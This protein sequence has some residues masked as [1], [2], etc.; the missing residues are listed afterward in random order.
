PNNESAYVKWINDADMV[1]LVTLLGYKM[2]ILILYLRLFA[3]NRT[4][5]Y[6]TW[7]M[8]FLVCGYLMANLLT[9]IFGCSPRSKYWEPGT[10]GHCI[11]YTTA[12]LAYGSMNIVS[13]L[14]ILIL[15]IP[16]VW[17]LELSRREK[18]SISVIFMSGTITCVA[19]AVRYVYIV[20]ENQADAKYFI[21]SLVEINIGVIC[22]CMPAFRPFFARVL[23]RVSIHSLTGGSW[24]SKYRRK[25][26]EPHEEGEVVEMGRYRSIVG[27]HHDSAEQSPAIELPVG[28][29]N[30]HEIVTKDGRLA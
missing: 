1:Y 25:N 11:D 18:V 7:S 2:S 17:Q 12:G 4:F 15:P 16:L 8:M 14:L 29:T 10:P 28:G 13:D 21:W 6:V 26:P 3:V 19:A 23:P 5:R 20:R 30:N 27:D 9:Q 24:R 22:S